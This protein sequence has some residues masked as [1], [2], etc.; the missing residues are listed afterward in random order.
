[1][2][3]ASFP[4]D[5]A[6]NPYIENFYSAMQKA[7]VELVSTE[8]FSTQWLRKNRASYDWVHLHW[9]HL[10]Y[11][12]PSL[13]LTVKKAVGFIYAL[14]YLRLILRKRI[15]YTLHNLYPHQSRSRTIDWIIRFFLVHLSN[16]VI[17][18]SRFAVKKARKHF[19]L[20]RSPVVM[21]HGHYLG[22]Y[23]QTVTREQARKKFGFNEEERVILFFG[24]VKKYKGV[25]D[26]ITTFKCIVDDR[27]RLIIAGKASEEMNLNQMVQDD[28]RIILDQSFIP[29][30][31]VQYYFTASDVVVFPFQKTLTS[32]SLMLAYSFK[33]PVILPAV[34]ELEEYCLEGA[35][36]TY[37]DELGIVLKT[38]FN[39]TR[40]ETLD[41]D[42]TLSPF[43]WK[44]VTIPV[45]EQLKLIG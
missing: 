13:F 42:K 8:F 10:Y 4:S 45:I 32:G 23:R 2:R 5:G 39:E 33:K 19:L 38:Y 27:F 34:A 20:L 40:D 9:P 14:I 25:E 30:D 21:H 7:D 15:L 43:D 26:L 1:M 18:H 12:N 41:W 11:D 17:A 36:V 31:D 44:A 28:K 3:I 29:E 22:N 24:N 35:S 6:G 16:L 37:S